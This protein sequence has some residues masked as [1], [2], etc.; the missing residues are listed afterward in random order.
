MKP[1]VNVTVAI[2]EAVLEWVRA[3]AARAN[4]SVSC[5]L[6]ALVAAERHREDAYESAMRCALKFEPLEFPAGLRHLTRDEANDRAR[7]G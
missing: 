2:D 3:K 1:L 6:G 7:R 4:T 5:W